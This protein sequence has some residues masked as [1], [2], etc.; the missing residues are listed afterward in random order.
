MTPVIIKFGLVKGTTYWSLSLYSVIYY[1]EEPNKHCSAG[2]FI[3]DVF[4][5]VLFFSCHLHL[6]EVTWLSHDKRQPNGTFTRVIATITCWYSVG[7]HCHLISFKIKIRKKKSQLLI[8]ISFLYSL[9]KH[10]RNK[11][12]PS[13]SLD[14]YLPIYKLVIWGI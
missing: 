2:N 10:L 8:I 3:S 9:L 12:W 11:K 5:K 4:S 7:L 1:F 14:W 13:F 6:C